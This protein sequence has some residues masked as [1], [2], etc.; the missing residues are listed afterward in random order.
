MLWFS[1]QQSRA[2]GVPGSVLGQDAGFFCVSEERQA[3]IQALP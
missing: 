2:R 3:Q 1:E